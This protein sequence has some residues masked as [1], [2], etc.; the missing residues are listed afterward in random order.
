MKKI[1]LLIVSGL[2]IACMAGS[3]MASPAEMDISPDPLNFI[4]DGVNIGASSVLVYKID[5]IS[6]NGDH[7]RTVTVKV[8]QNSGELYARINMG[9]GFVT[10]WASYGNPKQLTYNTANYKSSDGTVT[11]TLEVKGKV[12]GE[13]YVTDSYA[14]EAS[15]G[16]HDTASASPKSQIP[17]YPIAVGGAVAIGL[18]FMFGRKKEGL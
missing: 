18:L 16:S 9:N 17:E 7:D 10:D 2:L 12:G 5:Y 3:A 8:N 14:N 4:P 13:L 11:Y 1:L 15:N 6:N